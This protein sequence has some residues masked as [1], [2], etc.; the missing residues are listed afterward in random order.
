MQREDL[1]K[2]IDK[3]KKGYEGFKYLMLP[4]NFFKVSNMDA[5]DIEKSDPTA[6]DNRSIYEA[7]FTPLHDEILMVAQQA[8]GLNAYNKIKK[9]I[10]LF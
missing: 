8:Y 9:F 1:L 10:P 4:V 2:G 5:F 6:A 7:K 3:W